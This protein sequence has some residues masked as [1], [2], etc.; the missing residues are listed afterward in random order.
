M[1]ALQTLQY[2]LRSG[3]SD[4]HAQRRQALFRVV[5]ALLKGGM[6]WLSALGRFRCDPGQDKH[7]IKAVD[8]LLGNRALYRQRH[9]FYRALASWLLRVKRQPIVLVDITEI[10]AGVCALT[11]SVAL[12]GRSVPLYGIVR[13]KKTI[14]RRRTLVTFLNDLAAILPDGVIPIVVTD[15]GFESPWFDE[16]HQRGWHYVGRVRHRTR[17]LWHGQWLSAQELHAL[18]ATRARN[19]GSVPF[20]RHKPRARR[21]VLSRQRIH[22]GRRRNNTCRRKGRTANDRRCEKGAREPWLLA[23]SLSCNPAQVVEIYS[24]RMQIEQN[25]RDTKS[26]R[27]GWQLSLSGSRSNARLE[28]L[29]LIAVIATVAVLAVGAIAE[30]TKHHFRYQANTTRHRRV[31]SWFTIGVL[32]FQRN[33]PFLT[34]RNLALGLNKVPRLIA[35]IGHID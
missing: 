2:R 14:S 13:K 25:Y 30:H 32:C 29:L 9:V 4:I 31:L 3:L 21:L 23:T 22:K 17:F 5:E 27:W 28:M 18:A 12:S 35:T 6:L 7:G 1:R 10:R 8:R 20:P 11:A 34:S 16:V 33:D 26:H 15:A 19:L 24:T